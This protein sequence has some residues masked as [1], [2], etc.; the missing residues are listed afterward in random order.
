MKIIA[1][2]FIPFLLVGCNFSNPVPVNVAST[3]ESGF[4]LRWSQFPVSF[5][6]HVDFPKD[7]M[8]VIEKEIKELNQ[9]LGFE[10]L[11]IQSQFCE[12]QNKEDQINTLSWNATPGYYPAGRQAVTTIRWAETRLFEADIDFNPKE[13]SGIDFA[14]VTTELGV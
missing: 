8:I 4:P 9:L 1:F 7:K 10:A 11:K 3:N 13:L 14:L 12:A 2:L 5:Y 6:F